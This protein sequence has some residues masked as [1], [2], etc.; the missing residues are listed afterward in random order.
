MIV[1]AFGRGYSLYRHGPAR[2]REGNTLSGTARWGTGLPW[3][4][5]VEVGSQAKHTTCKRQLPDTRPH[6]SHRHR[7]LASLLHLVAVARRGVRC[8]LPLSADR[9]R[10]V[11]P[12]YARLVIVLPLFFSSALSFALSF[13]PPFRLLSFFLFSFSLFFFTHRRVF[14]QR[15][16]RRT[17]SR[18]SLFVSG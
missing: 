14:L 4:R 11:V 6:Q 5:S 17:R 3:E 8:S 12:R 15:S 10:V 7:F 1:V 2:G 18:P 9:R 13:S 16:Y